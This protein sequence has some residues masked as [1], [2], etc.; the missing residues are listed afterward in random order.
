MI[1][2]TASEAREI[3][4]HAMTGGWKDQVQRELSNILYTIKEVA[5][6]G[7]YKLLYRYTEIRDGS[8]TYGLAETELLRILTSE[9]NGYAIAGHPD[10]NV[11]EISWYPPRKPLLAILAAWWNK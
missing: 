5:L 11:I 8:R 2:M 10:S 6:H 1:S 4:E 7:D 3:A 9:D